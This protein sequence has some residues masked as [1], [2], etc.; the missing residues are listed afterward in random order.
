MDTPWEY[1]TSPDT[2]EIVWVNSAAFVVPSSHDQTTC[3]EEFG[4]TSPTRTTTVTI[5]TSGTNTWVGPTGAPSVSMSDAVETERMGSAAGT[6]STGVTNDS[7][8]VPL[9]LLAVSYRSVV[10]AWVVR[11]FSL[12]HPATRATSTIDTSRARHRT[13]RSS[14]RDMIRSLC[15]RPVPNDTD[16][17]RLLRRLQRRIV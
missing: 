3:S 16:A 1:A 17:L 15:T 12:A 8:A 10:P 9:V 14:D 6:G 13:W 7:F 4:S 11:V 2:I 5:G